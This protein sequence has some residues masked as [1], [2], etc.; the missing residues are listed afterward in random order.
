MT[1]E[2]S[3]I[4]GNHVYFFLFDDEEVDFSLVLDVCSSPLPSPIRA[5]AS[6]MT[7]EYAQ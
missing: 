5:N 1:I 3:N 2:G 7:V 4:A 6:R